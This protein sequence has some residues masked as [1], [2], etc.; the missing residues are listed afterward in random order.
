MYYKAVFWND[1]F[2]NNYIH[3]EHVTFLPFNVSL[4]LHYVYQM[5]CLIVSSEP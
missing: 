1:V 5:H 4:A 3:I 2:I